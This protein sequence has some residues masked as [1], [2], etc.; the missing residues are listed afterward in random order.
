MNYETT[1]LPADEYAD[2]YIKGDCC[3]AV[4]TS[5]D[6]KGSYLELDNGQKAYAY[7]IGNL[8]CGTKILCTITRPRQTG[9]HL[10]PSRALRITN[11]QASIKERTRI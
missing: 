11:K 8:S 3:Y 5:R 4:I 9:Q 2:R 7:G 10:R 6:S 1:M